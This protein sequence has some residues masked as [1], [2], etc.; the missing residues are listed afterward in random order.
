MKPPKSRA[1]LA[2]LTLLFALTSAQPAL[3]QVRVLKVFCRPL[4][5]ARLIWHLVSEQRR[6]IQRSVVHCRASR[7]RRHVHRL[8]V[9]R[10]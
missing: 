3:A 5:G 1:R 2:L 8:P 4:A 9:C 10:Q 6:P 7:Q